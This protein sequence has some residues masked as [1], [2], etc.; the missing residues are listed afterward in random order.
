[1]SQH[2]N[3]TL[4]AFRQRAPFA[5][6]F[7]AGCLGILASDRHPGCWPYWIAG[8]LLTTLFV[9][10][11]HSTWPALILAFTLFGFWHG[12]QV[13]I[14][15]GYQRSHQQPFDGDEHDVTLVVLSEPKIDQI[16]SFQRFVAHVRSIDNHPANFQVSAECSGESLS[17]GDG[18]EAQGKFQVPSKPLNPGQFDFGT[19]LRRESIYLNFRAQSKEPV[20]VTGHNQGNPLITFAL[21]A[22]HGILDSLV[23][24]LQ[25]DIEVAQTIQGMFLGARGE[26]SDELKRLFRDTGTIHLFAASGLQLGFFVGLAWSLLRRVRLPR[27]A[28]NLAVIP[29]AIAFCALTEFHPATV[30]AVVMAIFLAA[31]ASLE[32]PVATINSLCGSGVLI[33]I[34]DT[35]QLYQ[36]GFQLSFV[37]V[38]TIFTTAKPLAGLLYR[39][40]QVDAFMPKRL[41]APWQRAWHSAMLRICELFSLSAVCWVSTVPLLILEDHRISLVSVVANLLVVP[42]AMTVM[43]L[44]VASLAAGCVSSWIAACFNNTA[45]LITKGILAILHTLALIPGHSVNV[46]PA[47]LIASD[48]VTALAAGY[49]DIVHI[50]ACSHD[51]LM[52]TGRLTAWRNITAP[53]LRSQGVN[54]LD[55]LIV[56]DPPSHERKLLEE[57]QEEFSVRD[58]ALSLDDQFQT[59]PVSLDTSDLS[60]ASQCNFMEVSAT[61]QRGHLVAG[62]RWS[63]ITSILVHLGP[64]RVLILPIV[65][66]GVLA[67]LKKDH[68]DVVYCGRLRDRRFPRDLL[69]R[70]LSPSVLVMNGTKPELVANLQGNGAPPDCFFLKQ[71]GSVTTALFCGELRIRNFAG[72]ELRLPSRSR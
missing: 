44:G 61:G 20:T 26:P 34:H 31:G 9:F 47:S 1:M 19:Y 3:E 69:I 51:W 65:T 68:A 56:T 64:F 42:L 28:L 7:I 38:F 13:A 37:A 39:P 48:Q 57:L 70:K 58:N 24:G 16:Q 36:I 41:L 12:N 40:F 29:V 15:Q 30:R 59:T 46:S 67:A 5:G 33:L 62:A 18:I 11:V 53:Y 4:L 17:Y 50:H 55:R 14:D 43:L 45:W 72:S 49:D 23:E 8:F 10:K 21:A 22:R 32:R 54:R 2:S 63:S 52:N 71:G 66:E 25:E 35:Q 6:I 60:L 27:Q